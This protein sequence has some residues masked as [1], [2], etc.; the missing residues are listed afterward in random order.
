MTTTNTVRSVK[1]ARAKSMKRILKVTIKRMVDDSP[2]TSYLGEYAS[3]PTS[4]FSID[5]EHSLD[6]PINLEALDDVE[7]H[8]KCNGGNRGRNEFRYFNPSFN[9]VDKS[10]KLLPDNTA[11]EVRK[12]VRQ[13][14]ARMQA[15]NRGN[16][17]YMGVRAEAQ[18]QLDGDLRQTVIS[19]GLWG[20]ESDSDESY[21][22]DVE[23]EELAVLRS[24][25]Q[26]IGFSRRAIA[27]AFETV[28]RK[29]D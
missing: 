5:R 8:C 6:C 14:Y 13:D 2:D 23:R 29:E 17:C 25:L 19:G 20:I 28:E 27:A 15:A 3:S 11:E 10:G 12:Y 4:E 22:A 21:F 9:Y 24:Q 7:D 1:T 26:A 18:V 16:W